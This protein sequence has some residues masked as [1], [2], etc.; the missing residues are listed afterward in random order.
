MPSLFVVLR[1]LK[2]TEG[3]D[4]RFYAKVFTAGISDAHESPSNNTMDRDM[5]SELTKLMPEDIVSAVPKRKKHVARRSCAMV[6]VLTCEKPLTTN[7][8][9]LN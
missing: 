5:L 4:L 2:V 9:A 3:R 8:A 6:R 7:L 1:S